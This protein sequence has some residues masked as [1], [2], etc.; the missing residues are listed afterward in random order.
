[1]KNISSRITDIDN[2]LTKIRDVPNNVESREAFG[3][4]I[5]ATLAEQSR[6]LTRVKELLEDTSERIQELP[7]LLFLLFILKRNF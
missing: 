4:E 7:R 1:M 5:G 2:S 3:R 6:A